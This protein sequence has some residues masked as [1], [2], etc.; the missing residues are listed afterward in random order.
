MGSIDLDL[1]RPGRWGRVPVEARSL[2]LQQALAG[3]PGDGHVLLEDTSADVCVIGGGYVGLW[4]ALRIKEDDPAADVVLLEADICGGGA[5]G[6]NTG[7]VLPLWSKLSTLTSIDGSDAAAHI[8]RGSD[9]AV[10]EIERFAHRRGRDIGFRRTGWLWLASSSAQLRSWDGLAEACAAVGATPFIPVDKS[11]ARTR[12]GSPIY[13]G[14]VFMPGAAVLQPGLLA[15][16][17][18]SAAL[19]AGVAVYE[20]TPALCIRRNDA[21]VETPKATVKASTIISALGGWSGSLPPLR[22]SVVAV[23]AEIIATEPIGDRLDRSGWT[24]WEPVTNARLTLRY[25]RRTDDGRLVFGRAGARL[26]YGSRIDAKFHQNQRSADALKRELPRY[27][28]AARDAAVTHAWGG[29]VDR[30]PDGLPTFAELPG[31]GARLLYAAGFSGNG[32]APALLAARA[33]SA[34][35]LGRENEWT[36]CALAGRT[37]HRFPPE[38]IRY[39]GGRIVQAAVTAAEEREE[40]ERT[41]PWLLKRLSRLAPGG[42]AKAEPARQQAVVK[43]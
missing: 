41:A 12:T 1:T 31:R 34:L 7:Q 3:E 27:V 21:T 32:V 40:K 38:P 30:S 2:W 9:V 43:A 6:R 42:L 11:E 39:F 26:A 18:R 29:P 22:R 10:D 35:A 16:E 24:G 37:G 8:A 20:H 19:E 5:S 28:P 13:L 17:L 23:A 4:T 36:E 14:G 25:T 33:L 15:R